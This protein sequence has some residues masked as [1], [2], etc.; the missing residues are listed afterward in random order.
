M[1][2]LINGFPGTGKLTIARILSEQLAMARLEP[3]VGRPE[4]EYFA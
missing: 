3:A 2:I 1:L 4:R